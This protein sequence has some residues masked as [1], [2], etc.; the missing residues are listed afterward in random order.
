M[1]LYGISAAKIV[2]YADYCA[3]SLV[4]F[5][6]ILTFFN[7]VLKFCPAPGRLIT[8]IRYPVEAYNG[9]ISRDNTSHRSRLAFR[10]DW[11]HNALLPLLNPW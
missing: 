6:V 7:S 3:G 10:I 2:A 5:L 9:R 1:Y 11:L 8:Q 4:H